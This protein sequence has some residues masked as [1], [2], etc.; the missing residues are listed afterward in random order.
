MDEKQLLAPGQVA[1]MF[2]VDAKTVTRWAKTGKIRS[3]MTPGGQ[4][5]FDPEEIAGLM[6]WRDN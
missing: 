2:G 4:R 3:V 5:R 6:K 1:R